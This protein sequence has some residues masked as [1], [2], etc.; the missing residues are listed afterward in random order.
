MNR[1]GALIPNSIEL[2][3]DGA[4]VISNVPDGHIG[5]IIAD[6]VDDRVSA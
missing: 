1:I 3:K 4:G 6:L 5:N 2:V